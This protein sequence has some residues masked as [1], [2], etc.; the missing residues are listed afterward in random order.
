M[1]IVCNN[2]VCL[3]TC[4]NSFVSICE[5][6]FD[7]PNTA[8]RPDS[9]CFRPCR[10]TRIRLCLKTE[11]F[12]FFGLAYRL[13]QVQKHSPE[14]RGAFENTGLSLR[15]GRTRENRHDVTI[16]AFLCGRTKNSSNTPCVDAIFF[17]IGEKISFFKNI[18]MRPKCYSL[19]KTQMQQF[20]QPFIETV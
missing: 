3:C 14:L 2:K 13:H 16:V 5:L 1:T 10:F 6:D 17:K 15:C 18:R 4:K 20:N 7:Q 19:A 12:F 11:S 9:G 8:T